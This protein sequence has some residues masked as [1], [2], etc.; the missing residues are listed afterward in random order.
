MTERRAKTGRWRAVRGFGYPADADVRQ[1]IRDGDHGIPMEE[2]GP[3]VEIAAGET[4]LVDDLPADVR[5]VCLRYAE[6][7]RKKKG[8]K[9]DG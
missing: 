3:A 4:F 5:D 1:R 6:P 7:V 8:G 2:R 9:N